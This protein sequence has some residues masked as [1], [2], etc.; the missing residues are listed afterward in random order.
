M[1]AWTACVPGLSWKC[2]YKNDANDRK[3]AQAV[4]NGN[5]DEAILDRAVKRMLQITYRV[6]EYATKG[7]PYDQAV[8][9]RKAREIAAECM[10]LLKNDEHLLPLPEKADVAVLGAFA[11]TP[12]YQGG[13]A[14]HV[15]AGRLWT[16]RLRKSVTSRQTRFTR[17]AI[18]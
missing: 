15:R 11:E 18:G 9:H 3:I 16:A 14:A 7:A 12:R 10:V 4:R 2:P 1:T 5:L 6:A 17:P 13:G 8:H